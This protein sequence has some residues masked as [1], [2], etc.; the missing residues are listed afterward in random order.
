MSTRRA[1]LARS[2]RDSTLVAL[3][4]TL[5]G[6]LAGAARAAAPDRDGRIL[7]VVQLDGGNDGINTLVPFADDGYARHRKALRL[8]ERRLIKID[9]QVGLHPAMGAAGAL[10]ESGRL[11]IV[12]GVGY[13]N[14]SRSHFQSREIWQSARFDPRDRDGTG[15]IGRALDQG[16][17]PANGAPGAILLETDT[18]PAAVRGRRSACAALDRLD[19]Y[20]LSGRGASTPTPPAPSD[21]LGAYLRRSLL[22][23]YATA[24]R[25]GAVARDGDPGAAYPDGPLAERLRLAARLIKAGL[26]TRVY[27]LTQG[28]YDTHGQQL[29]RHGQLLGELCGSIKA[30]L[31]DLA[32]AGLAERVLVLCFSEFGRRVAENGTAGTDHGTAGP[33]LLAGPGVRPGLHGRVPSLTDLE[34]GDLKTSVDFRRVYA[35]ALQGWLGLPT[36]PALGAGFDPLPL[37]RG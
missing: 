23:A 28:D 3:A 34:D 16:P 5:P 6:F 35:T 36:G 20:A 10:L 19:D 37:L 1:F 31:D 27:Y 30:F 29:P 2:L 8:P 18:P 14:P 11:A 21:D 22:D 33:V 13:P 32:A 12:P 17:V 25:L 24:D 26:G 7:V 9:D 15:W 4:P